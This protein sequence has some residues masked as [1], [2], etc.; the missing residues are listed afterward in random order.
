MLEDERHLF[1]QY[2]QFTS[3]N[4]GRK[5][6]NFTRWKSETLYYTTRSGGSQGVVKEIFLGHHIISQ[7][8]DERHNGN[9]VSTDDS[10]KMLIFLS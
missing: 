10:I 9:H 8:A 2:H 6:I 4:V 1:S 3:N 5:M 7:E